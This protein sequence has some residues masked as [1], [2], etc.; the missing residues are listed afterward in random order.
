MNRVHETLQGLHL[1]DE[2]VFEGLT[3]FPL[4]SENGNSPDYL[5]LDQA[6]ERGTGRVTEVSEGGSVPEL[7][8]LN[9]GEQPVLLVDGEELVG[10]KQNRTLNHTILVA[11][12]SS[13]VIPVTCVEQG[14]WSY[15]STEFASAKRSHF[16]RA[17]AAK[18]A[19][20]SESLRASGSR[21]ADQGQVW[22]AIEAKMESF[23]A[24]SPTRAMGDLYE[25]QQ[26]GIEAYAAALPTVEGQVGAAFAGNGEISG[27]DLFD[28]PSTL[29]A[30]WP[31]L[32][33]SYALDAIEAKGRPVE[34]SAPVS[35]REAATQFLDR[36][37][38]AAVE[39]FP[40]LGLGEDLRLRAPGVAGGALHVKDR[41]VHLSAF[42]VD[43]NGNQERTSHHPRMASAS[44]RRATRR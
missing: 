10:A 38:K 4:V 12:K 33:S 3:V 44:R 39:T 25:Q 31:K 41:V 21:H 23:A 8:F 11:A 27:V 6:L 32:V 40:A 26:Q 13:V 30:L 7:R 2:I 28:C 42:R 14:R 17:R 37:G 5:T 20:V 16:A 43:G 24:S 36:V 1:G 15:R 35:P 18:A 34:A 9:E 19:Q 22:E 29:R